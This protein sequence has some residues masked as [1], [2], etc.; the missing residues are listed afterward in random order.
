MELQ[1]EAERRKRAQV[2]AA[3]DVLMLRSSS[4]DGEAAA[5]HGP[6]PPWNPARFYG[7]KVNACINLHINV[8]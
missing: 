3:S 6:G 1:A 7:A 5:W 8:A 2:R 4:A